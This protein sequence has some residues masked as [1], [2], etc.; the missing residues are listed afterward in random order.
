AFQ[1]TFLVLARRAPALKWRR[2]AAPWL[3]TV[4]YRLALRLRRQE[5]RRR[6]RDQKAAVMSSPRTDAG[7]WQEVQPI[8][9]EEVNRLPS[10][11]RARWV[12]GYLEGKT[13]DEP[14]AQ[15]A[16]PRGTVAGRLAR[17]KDLL[18]QR[19]TRRGVTLGAGLV[20]LELGGAASASVPT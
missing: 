15:L 5:A 20:G 8:L 4:A 12:L 16:W 6:L 1:A 9:D 7:W 2:T 3:Y 18:R 17:A 13:V 11:Y 10:R 19:L 14:P